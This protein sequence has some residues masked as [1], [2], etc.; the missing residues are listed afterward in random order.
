MANSLQNLL[1]RIYG[2]KTFYKI[3]AK[4]D[5]IG[6]SVTTILSANPNRVSFLVVNL[7]TANLFMSPDNDVSSSKGIF[8]A[9]NGGSV[10]LQWDVDFELVSQTWYAVASASSSDIYILENIII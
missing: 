2:L 6:T 4:A 1:E 5:S 9:P 10:I 8:V 7:S 3:N